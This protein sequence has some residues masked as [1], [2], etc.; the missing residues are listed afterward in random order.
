MGKNNKKITTPPDFYE[1]H[2]IPKTKPAEDSLFWRLFN[3]CKDIAQQALAT[4][5]MQ[6]IKNGTL[7]PNH[8]GSYSVMD[9]YYC[10]EGAE[11]YRS[12]SS[13]ATDPALKAMLEHKHSSYDSYNQYI[14]DTWGLKNAEGITPNE[15]VRNYSALEKKVATQEA[16]IYS[17]IVMLPC[18]YLW[19]WLAEQLAGYEKDNLYAFWIKENGSASGAYAMGN[20]IEQ[21]QVNYKG[22][23]QAIDEALA[24]EYYKGAMEGEHNDFAARV[25]KS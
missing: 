4:D 11:D 21:Y 3:E 1:S 22:T 19:P 17:L 20:F 5:F 2:G 25:P 6:G 10:F 23:P 7:D 13:R 16:P 12:A 9:A 24:L 15:A 8:Y 18:E 14:T